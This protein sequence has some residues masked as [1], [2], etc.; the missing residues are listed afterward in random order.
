[1]A[2]LLKDR[3]SWYSDIMSLQKKYEHA[4]KAVAVAKKIATAARAATMVEKKEKQR[5]IRLLHT[6]EEAELRADVAAYRR[7]RKRVRRLYD[8]EVVAKQ[9]GI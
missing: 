4:L 9:L 6:T 5:L 2:T 3:Q 8:F 7:A 1:M